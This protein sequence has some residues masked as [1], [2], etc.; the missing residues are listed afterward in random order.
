MRSLS[1]LSN[2]HSDARTAERFNFS[3]S[4]H[5][6]RLMFLTRLRGFGGYPRYPSTSATRPSLPDGSCNA[7]PIA[8]VA[9]RW[10]APF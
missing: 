1:R 4:F 3:I 8:D 7:L 5:A 10:T 2:S 6:V 9:L